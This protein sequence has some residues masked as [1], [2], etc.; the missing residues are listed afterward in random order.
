[1]VAKIGVDTAGRIPT[2]SSLQAYS[3]ADLV[4]SLAG[5]QSCLQSTAYLQLPAATSRYVHVPAVQV[6][7]SHGLYPRYSLVENLLEIIDYAI[8]RVGLAPLAAIP[9][10]RISNNDLF[11]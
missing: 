5:E 11:S 9:F 8:M 2:G 4:A 6:P 7:R 1:M 3:N 10:Q